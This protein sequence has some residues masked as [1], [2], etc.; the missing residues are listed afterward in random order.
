MRIPRDLCHLTPDGDWVPGSGP[1]GATRIWPYTQ[2]WRWPVRTRDPLRADP[3]NLFVIGTDHVRMMRDLAPRGWSRPGDGGV[4][5]LWIDRRLRVMSDHVALGGRERRL[6]ARL[7]SIPAG[8]LVAA[9]EEY[10]DER[11][12]AHVV[13]SWDAARERIVADLCAAGYAR[14]APSAIVAR[15]AL[16]GVPGDG[17]I[18]RLVAP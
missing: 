4:H 18:W 9:H 16:R 13:T 12:D 2:H 17:R 1:R 15:P 10:L 5:R 11:R 3:V 8:C 14:L 7:W 6:H